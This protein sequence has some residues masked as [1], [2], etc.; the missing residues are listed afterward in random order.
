MLQPRGSS[1]PTGAI[2]YPG[3]R[4][5]PGAM[6]WLGG[7]SGSLVDCGRVEPAIELLIVT[8]IPR[9]A[10]CGASNARRLTGGLVLLGDIEREIVDE[11]VRN[12]DRIA[13]GLG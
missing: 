12:L 6:A 13:P 2:R 8:S 9:V 11:L 10:V 5:Q 3:E 1:S 7:L 4:T